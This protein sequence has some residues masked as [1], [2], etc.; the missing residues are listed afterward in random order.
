MNKSILFF[1]GFILTRQLFAQC[2]TDMSIAQSIKKI[3]TLSTD[4]SIAQ[5]ENLYKVSQPCK[6]LQDSTKGNICNNLAYNYYIK[7]ESE[8]VLTYSKASL[9][10]WESY[11]KHK[12]MGL[13]YATYGAAAYH[14]VF[15]RY[16]EAIKYYKLTSDYATDPYWKSYPLRL[17]SELYLELGD[18][19]G[20][21]TI[22]DKAEQFAEKASL[23]QSLLLKSQIYN[24]RGLAYSRL[25]DEEKAI[26][27]FLSGQRFYEQYF[28]LS[29][30]DDGELKGNIF[31]S[32]AVS[33]ANIKQLKPA[34]ENFKKAEETFK[35]HKLGSLIPMRIYN[36]LGLLYTSLRRY[37]QAAILFNK[38]IDALKG[39]KVWS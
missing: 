31:A 29:K 27:N 9:K 14:H 38:A 37:K 10:Y 20:M 23:T 24:S 21:L 36:N 22:L 7:N 16:Q 35:Q 39:K 2:P 25:E 32:M 8:K 15:L 11:A 13:T 5:L 4:Q 34:E 1:I 17:I 28:R 26:K 12:P 18:Y 33:Y 6:S 19:E 3:T 30:T